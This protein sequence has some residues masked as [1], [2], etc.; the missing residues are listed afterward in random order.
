MFS[1]EW[2]GE[3]P[4]L[5][6]HQENEIPIASG[7]GSSSSAVLAGLFGANELAGAPLAREDV[8]QIATDLEGHPDNVAPAVYGGLV[9]GVQ[10]TNGLWVERFPVPPMQVLVVLPD[11][12]LLTETARAVLPTQVPLADAIFNSSRIGL[13]IH[14]L[15]TADYERLSVAMQDR[16]HQPYRIPI[17]PGMAEAMQAAYDAGAAAVALSGAGPSLIAFA[18]GE[19]EQISSAAVEAFKHAGASS[20]QWQLTLDNSGVLIQKDS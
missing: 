5:S 16:L 11:F 10:H 9:L 18:A 19:Y 7:L 13:L 20:R 3:P 2:A 15:Q 1:E 17:I 4:G 8:L 6:I 14:A 12:E